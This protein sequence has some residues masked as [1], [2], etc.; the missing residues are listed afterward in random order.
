MLSTAGEFRRRDYCNCAEGQL[1]FSAV[2]STDALKY[3][4]GIQIGGVLDD[5]YYYPG[6]LGVIFH[7]F[8]I[9][10][11]IL[12]TILLRSDQAMGAH[13]ARRSLQI[14]NHA[15]DTSPAAI[16]PMKENNGVWTANGNRNWEG[17]YYLYSVNVY[18]PSDPPSTPTSPLI[19]TRSTSL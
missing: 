2:D 4:T 16:I 18:V 1:A 8:T 11:V 5:L 13:R 15:A 6:K 17:K 19:P 12:T 14:F 3:A 7:H 10:S 9:V